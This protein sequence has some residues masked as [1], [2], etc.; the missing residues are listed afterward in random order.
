VILS[1]TAFAFNTLRFDHR[2]DAGERLRAAFFLY[3]LFMELLSRFY[4]R[5]RTFLV[6]ADQYCVTAGEFTMR[7][8]AIS[9]SIGAMGLDYSQESN[10]RTHR[11]WMTLLLCAITGSVLT[12]SFG[13][14]LAGASLLQIIEPYGR[15]ALLGTFLL[16]ITF[17]ILVFAAHCLDKIEDTN[18]AQRIA[19][20]RRMVYG[21]SVIEDSSGS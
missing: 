12:G 2:N 9:H 21:G 11:R 10:R 18:R 20:Y 15:L 7:S 3:V 4:V 17:P 6:D 8:V 16:A 1:G 19:S 13:L 5:R 14:V